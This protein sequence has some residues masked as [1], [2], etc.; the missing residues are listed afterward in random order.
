MYWDLFYILLNNK[1]SKKKPSSLQLRLLSV[2]EKEYV[3]KF[4]NFLHYKHIISIFFLY[5]C[6]NRI[7]ITDMDL[8]H[9]NILSKKKGHYNTGWNMLIHIGR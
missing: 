9:Y 2:F 6:I 7:V 1:K 5:N 4:E 8:G 3:S